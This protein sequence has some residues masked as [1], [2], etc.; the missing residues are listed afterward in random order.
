MTPHSSAAVPFRRRC[1]H[2]AGGDFAELP[3]KRGVDVG[4][5]L[6]ADICADPLVPWRSP[7]ASKERHRS[8]CLTSVRS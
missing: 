7:V 1:H 4:E 5:T 6:P 3:L 8:V 2:D